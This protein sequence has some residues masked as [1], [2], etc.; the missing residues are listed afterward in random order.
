VKLLLDEENDHVGGHGAPDLRIDSVLVGAIKRLDAQVLL[1]PFEKQFDLP[2][3]A[4]QVCNLL[5]FECE[6]VGQK[7]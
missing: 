3:L 2:A 4:V 1:Y 5:G 7:M 6:V